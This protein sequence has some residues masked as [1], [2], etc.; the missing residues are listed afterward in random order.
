MMLLFFHLTERKKI[1]NTFN[2]SVIYCNS[3]HFPTFGCLSTKEDRQNQGIKQISHHDICITSIGNS[4]ANYSNLQSSYGIGEKLEAN[5][6]CFL[7][8]SYNYFVKELEVFS[9]LVKK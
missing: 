7:A 5:K 3:S 4:F 8:G 9:V 2:D 1:K 6:R